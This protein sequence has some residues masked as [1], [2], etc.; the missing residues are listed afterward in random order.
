MCHPFRLRTQQD[1]SKAEL[2]VQLPNLI[3]EFND[4][5]NQLK[6][7]WL[8]LRELLIEE[9]ELARAH[10][11][12]TNCL[13]GGFPFNQVARIPQLGADEERGY[14]KISSEDVPLFPAGRRL[15]P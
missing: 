15:E 9:A 2:A 12:R 8:V 11:E 10:D 5:A 6:E 14:L 1:K 13:L 3:I 7:K 4:H